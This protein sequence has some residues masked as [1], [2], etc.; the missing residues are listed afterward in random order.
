MKNLTRKAQNEL[1]TKKGDLKKMYASQIRMHATNTKIYPVSYSGRGRH[2]NIVD[3][4]FYIKNAIELLGYK[5][6]TGNDAPKGGA[7]GNFIKISKK[8]LAA[9]NSLIAER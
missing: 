2:I 4:S 3:N 6:S 1:Y 5:Y 9:L 7:S 8:A